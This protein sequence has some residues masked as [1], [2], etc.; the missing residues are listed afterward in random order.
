[1]ILYKWTWQKDVGYAGREVH[2]KLWP[3]SNIEWKRDRG[4][5]ITGMTLR[6]RSK[7]VMRR[8]DKAVDVGIAGKEPRCFTE[9]RTTEMPGICLHR[10]IHTSLSQYDM[11]SDTASV[12][13]SQSIDGVLR[14]LLQI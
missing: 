14:V 13:P 12:R 6:W 10:F 7:Y 5:L 11:S 2:V 4:L 1:M 3:R 8:D 9:G